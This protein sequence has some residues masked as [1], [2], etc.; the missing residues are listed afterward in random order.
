M[1]YISYWHQDVNK[2]DIDVVSNV[3]VRFPDDGLRDAD[4]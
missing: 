2:E 4:F 1:S 3:A